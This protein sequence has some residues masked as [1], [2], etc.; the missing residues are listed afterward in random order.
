MIAVFAPPTQA[1]WENHRPLNAPKPTNSGSKTEAVCRD[2]SLELCAE[3]C[4]DIYALVTEELVRLEP[5]DD[6]VM[7]LALVSRVAASAV[8]PMLPWCRFVYQ[9]GLVREH[10]S[11]RADVDYRQAA[12]HWNHKIS[13]F[14]EAL[15]T[16]ENYSQP[17][18][19]RFSGWKAKQCIALARQSEL[20]FDMYLSQGWPEMR[21]GSGY[22]ANFI[23]LS[24]DGRCTMWGGRGV[25]HFQDTECML[26]SVLQEAADT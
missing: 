26:E 19:K 2:M 5:Q 1:Q 8:L 25:Q 7:H 4:P 17:I 16:T 11:F 9:V 14:I 13:L 3:L 10:S 21:L 23:N 12:Q 22:S 6:T 15:N 24:P 18:T 20:E